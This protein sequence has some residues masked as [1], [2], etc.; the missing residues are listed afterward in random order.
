MGKKTGGTRSGWRDISIDTGNGE[1]TL[2][3]EVV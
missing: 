3:R 1:E 2:F